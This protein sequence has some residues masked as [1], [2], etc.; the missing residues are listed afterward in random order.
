MGGALGVLCLSDALAQSP[1]AEN[2]YAKWMDEALAGKSPAALNDETMLKEGDVAAAKTKLWAEYKAAA[3]RAGWDK[4][5]LSVPEPI[6]KMTAGGKK[7]KLQA[8][9]LTSDDKTMPYLFMAKGKKPAAGWPMFICLHGG[10][11][12]KVDTA[13]GWD[14]NT[15]EWQAQMSLTARVYKPAGLYFIPRMADDRLGRWWHKHNIDI[16]TRMIRDAILFNDVDSNKI[17]IMGIS[18]GGYG[19]CHLTPFLA[20]LFAGGGSM[21]GGMMTVTENLRNVA[22][23]SDIGEKDTMFK[24]IELAKELHT[25]IDALKAKDPDG[26]ENVLAIQEGRG[27]GIDYSKSP[28]WLITHTRNPYPTKIVWRCYEKAGLYRDN[29]YWLSLTKTPEKGE[30][31]LTASVDKARNLVT[32]TAEEV[33][34]AKE[35]DGKATRKPLTSSK[36]TVNLNDDM[37][38]LDQEVTVMLNGKQ[39]FKGKL[40]RSRFTMMKNLVK[41]GDINYAFPA[42]VTVGG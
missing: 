21:A 39:V 4:H 19:T 26:Y 9:K 3:K 2:T 42:E 41:R 25:S 30:F 6:E 16:F 24:R 8:G 33:I 22:F 18:Q 31:D 37:V 34:P 28:S 12:H 17:Y 13:H 15:R 36:V 7:P 11:Q 27:H 10:G 14:V 38:D 32:I 20:D 5:L 23:R 35:K 40:K 1:I 29:F